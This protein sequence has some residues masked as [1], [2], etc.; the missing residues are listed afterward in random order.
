MS[1]PP[2]LLTLHTFFDEN[3]NKFASLFQKDKFFINI[4]IDL[5]RSDTKHCPGKAPLQRKLL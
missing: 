2:C 3:I 4:F 1:R 5:T